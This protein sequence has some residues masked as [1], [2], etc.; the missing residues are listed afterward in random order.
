MFKVIDD[1]GKGAAGRRTIRNFRPTEED[2]QVF[3]VSIYS[4]DVLESMVILFR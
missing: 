4:L 3:N 2:K 1:S